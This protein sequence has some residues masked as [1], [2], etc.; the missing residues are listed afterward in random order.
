VAF[1]PGLML[2]VALLG[3]RRLVAERRASLLLGI[4][5]VAVAVWAATRAHPSLELLVGSHLVVALLGGAALRP[6]AERTRVAVLTVVSALALVLVNGPVPVAVVVAG[7]ALG[8]AAERSEALRDRR[9]APLVQGTLMLATLAACWI[10]WTRSLAW[11]LAAQGLFA[12]A[13][14]RHVSWLVDT[15]RGTGGTLLDVCWY[16]LFYPSCYGAAERYGD[17]RLRN[18]SPGAHRDDARLLRAFLRSAAYIWVVRRLPLDLPALM[19]VTTWPAFA[20]G[21]LLFF[22]RAALHVMSLWAMLEATALAWG[23]RIHPNFAGILTARSPSQF[24]RAWRGTM[25]RWLIDYVYVP[26]G[27]N[28][29]HP[30]RNVFAVFAVSA[31]WHWMGLPF[32][33]AETAPADFVPIGAWALVN[34]TVLA[35]AVTGRRRGWRFWPRVTPAGVRLAVAVVG[36]WAFGGVTATFLAFHGDLAPRFPEFVARLLGLR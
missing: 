9:A 25:T 10:V 28:R 2:V 22:V 20:A 18:P 3:L 13:L 31:A 5:A 23:V 34:A 33:H 14:L 30:V 19:E 21:Y 4:P 11:G 35:V 27:G 26:L 15:R 17:F 7:I 12:F 24:W 16:Q 8:I 6:L 29:A 32:L 36:T 1:V